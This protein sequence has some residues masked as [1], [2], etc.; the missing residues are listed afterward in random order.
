[1]DD[2]EQA[3][4]DEINNFADIKIGAAF[5]ADAIKEADANLELRHFD[6]PAPNKTGIWIYV[7]AELHKLICTESKEYMKEKK[8]ISKSATPTITFIT[9]LLVGKFGFPIATAAAIVGAVTSICLKAGK[10]SWCLQ[11][12]SSREAITREEKS[13]AYDIY[14]ETHLDAP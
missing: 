6:R 11:Y 1:M 2:V 13:I 14:Q 4:I 8:I 12:K 5:L 9:G 3:W 10:N 7:R